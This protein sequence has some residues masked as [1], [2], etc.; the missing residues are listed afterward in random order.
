VLR[1]PLE[2]DLA[3][4]NIFVQLTE[5]YRRERTRRIEAGDETARLKFSPLA[6]QQASNAK[7]TG[8]PPVAAGQVRLAGA[9]TG[10]QWGAG[11]AWA[12]NQGW[13]RW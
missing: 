13:G 12:G 9:W 2:E 10:N 5:E 3:N 6:M 7:A 1:T 4:N 11:G 8:A